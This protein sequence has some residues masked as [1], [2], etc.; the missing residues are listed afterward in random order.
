[1]N[2]MMITKVNKT[3]S[4]LVVEDDPFSQELLHSMLNGYNYHIA[5]TGAEAIN[6]YQHGMQDIV[7]L[8]IGLPD[9]SGLTVINEIH[10][11]NPYTPI[12][13]LTSNNDKH[14]V[15]QAMEK[16]ANGY[17]VKP[18]S[19]KLIDEHIARLIPITIFPQ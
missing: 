15:L 17:I 8:E 9:M 13:M 10:T 7:F 19:K 14:T 12:V 1:M 2:R 11:M 18:V 5:A 4:L 3:F 16:G 6:S